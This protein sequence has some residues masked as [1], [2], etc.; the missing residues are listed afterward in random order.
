MRT[1]RSHLTARSIR[2]NGFT[3]VE[4][5]VVIM[6]SAVLMLLAVPGILHTR[7]AA[8]RRQSN[9]YLRQFELDFEIRNLAK[10]ST[11]SLPSYVGTNLGGSLEIYDERKSVLAISA[12]FG[13]MLA[14]LFIVWTVQFFNHKDD[15]FMVGG[16]DERRSSAFFAGWFCPPSSSPI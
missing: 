9:E 7:E 5:L 14:S 11:E 1:C 2:S 8:R 6:I 15:S 3:R 4:L 10:N 16:R 13:A 12:T